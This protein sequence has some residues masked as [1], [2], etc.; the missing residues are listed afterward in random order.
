MNCDN[1]KWF[2]WYY[3]LC[4]KWNCKVDYRSVYNCFEERET[5]ILDFMAKPK[6]ET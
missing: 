3:D 6:E 4:K 1:C 5:P 2:N